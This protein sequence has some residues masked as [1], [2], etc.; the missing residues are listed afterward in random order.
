MIRIITDSTTD[1]DR[2]LIAP[3]DLRVLPLTITID[4][5]NYLDGEEIQIDDVYRA[6]RAGIVPKT[7]LIPPQRVQALFAELLAAGD[8][9]IYIAFSGELSGC[10]AMADAIARDMQVEYP[11]RRITVVDSRGGSS[12]T[13]LIVLQALKMAA[14][15]M[16]YDMLLAQINDMIAHVE[17][18]FSVSDMEWLA[19]GGRVPRIVGFI[20]GKLSI[21]PLLNVENGRMVV[22]RMI[23]GNKK[24]IAVVAAEIA[25][26]AR[27]FPGQLIAISHADDAEAA[28]SLSAQ[29]LALLPQCRTTI[30]HIG[31][32]IGV[33]I[34]L[35]GIGA[36]CLT[37]RPAGYI[38]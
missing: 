38:D 21:R 2:A 11:A 4:N 12:A 32:V 34:G 30:C 5:T 37:A 36:Y 20:G 22:R 35:S 6:M 1:I 10:F 33:H 23:R 19:K 29:I 25:R 27:A 9:V 17:H 7:S 18:V 16:D 3:Y 28:S 14:A 26:R 8:D 31:G 15:G 24:A 13:G